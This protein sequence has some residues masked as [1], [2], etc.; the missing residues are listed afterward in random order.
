V[1]E[2]GFQ[3]SSETNRTSRFHA[4]SFSLIKI[5][6][7]PPLTDKPTLRFR[8]LSQAIFQLAKVLCIYVCARASSSMQQQHSFCQQLA[9]SSDVDS[10]APRPDIN[11]R[12]WRKGACARVVRPLVHSPTHPNHPPAHSYLQAYRQTSKQTP[13]PTTTTKPGCGGGKQIDWNQ[14]SG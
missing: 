10:G 8:K 14:T 12:D 13:G 1:A 5:N 7:L 3:L 6:R 4:T 11:T 2:R 9:P